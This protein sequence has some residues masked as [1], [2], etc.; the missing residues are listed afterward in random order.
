MIDD[1]DYLKGKGR[2]SS[3]IKH[4]YS[5]GCH[6]ARWR[7]PLEKLKQQRLTPNIVIAPVS[8]EGCRLSP[9]LTTNNSLTFFSEQ[10]QEKK[11]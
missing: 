1:D 7:K 6:S 9:Q 11:I 8:N 10:K 3:P 4:G 5:K 2:A